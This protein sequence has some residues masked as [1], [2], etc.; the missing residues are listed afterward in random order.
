MK[1]LLADDDAVSRRILR[2]TLERS[3]FEVVCADD[4]HEAMEVLMA[5][6]PPRVAI[7]DWVMPGKDGPTV[8]REVR[9]SLETPYVYMILLTAK[10]TSGDVVLGLES[11]ADDYLVKPCNPQ[12]LKA[13]IRAGQRI[14]DLQDKLIFEAEH[15]SLTGLPNRGYFVRKLAEAVRRTHLEP[16]YQF[17]LLFVDV[18]RFKVINDSLG[19]VTG[20]GLMRAIAERLVKAVRTEDTVSRERR[21][22]RKGRASSDVVARIGGDEFVLLLDQF[23]RVDDGI[24]VAERVQGML[25]P[26][27]LVDGHEIFVTAS[28]GISTSGEG[29][30]DPEEILRGADTAM[31]KAK[32]L[33][34]ARYEVSDG[35]GQAAA[36][37]GF[38]MERDLRLAI[39]REEFELHYQPI[40]D[41]RDGHVV[42][43]EALVRWRHPEMGMV[44]PGLFISMAEESGLIVPMGEW[45]LREACR[46]TQVWNA[47]FAGVD[48][49]GV[50]VNI[51]PKQFNRKELV[52]RVGEVLLETGLNPGC[53]ELE[54]T[55]N[56]TMQDAMRTAEVMREF[57][58]LGVALSLDDFGTGYSSLSYLKRFPIGTLKIDRSFVAD[59]ERSKESC[60]I[61]QTIVALGHR[62]GLKVVGEGIETEAQR[63]LLESFGCD[64]GQGFLFSRPVPAEKAVGLLAGFA[65]DRRQ[66]AA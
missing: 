28:I 64:L 23:G 41:L 50:T 42:S 51:S 9:A 16:G 25:G 24:R 40:V 19:H 6:D 47:G 4:G 7:L 54:V 34:K 57:R 45:V 10:E 8:C 43:F 27:F 61:V 53:L 66:T 14:L 38:R 21:V 20:D 1:I 2:R 33:G 63:A 22:R 60:E 29:A 46:Q 30:I 35:S 55:E 31:Y 58:E 56:L 37:R 13:R 36:Q 65:E 12:E 62:L 17:S 15:D 59:M 48:T 49:L 44:Q 3:G 39:Q 52:E 5:P 18:D 32:R 11:G 26:A